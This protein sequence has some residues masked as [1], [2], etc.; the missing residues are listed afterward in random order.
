MDGWST[1]GLGRFPRPRR[2]LPAGASLSIASHDTVAF[3]AILK[4]QSPF[5]LNPMVTITAEPVGASTVQTLTLPAHGTAEASLSFTLPVTTTAGS[6]IVQVDVSDGMTDTAQFSYTVPRSVISAIPLPPERAL[7]NALGV[8]LI[9]SGGQ[10]TTASYSLKLIDARGVQIAVQ[11]DSQPVPAGGQ[12]VLSLPIPDGLAAGTYW[13]W[14][15]R[16]GFC[17]AATLLA[18]A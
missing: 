9:N 6:Y 10:D 13:L 2:W 5:A 12:V 3:T 14:L 7:S 17:Y 8:L 1:K 16:P 15:A 11:N 18:A 4:S